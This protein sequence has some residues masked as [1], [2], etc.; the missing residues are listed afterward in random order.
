MERR[1]AILLMAL[2]L[3]FPAAAADKNTQD[4]PD[5]DFS[6][7]I[8]YENATCGTG[9]FGFS[10]LYDRDSDS[11]RGHMAFS[12]SPNGSC[13]GQGLSIDTVIEKQHNVRGNL[14]TVV[15]GGYDRRTVP[16]EY[17]APYGGSNFKFFRGT[18]VETASA[19]FGFGYD[20]GENRYVQV[21]Y[22]AVENRLN[23]GSKLNPI[24]LVASYEINDDIELNATTNFDT[25]QFGATWDVGPIELSAN[26]SVDFQKLEHPAPMY[27]DE[28]GQ[29]FMRAGS[30]PTL[31]HFAARWNF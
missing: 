12:G 9:E 7:G 1:F 11:I 5:T 20:L 6:A 14:F 31:Y 17:L 23:D 30:K 19:H 27:L 21:V 15:G 26:V 29:M 24:S 16:F 8:D 25:H 4:V 13:S 10:T 2:L 22:N 18:T 3:A 28:G